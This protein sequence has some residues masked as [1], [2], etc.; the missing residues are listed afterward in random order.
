[1]W[2]TIH[3]ISQFHSFSIALNSAEKINH[4]LQNG[5]Q[6]ATLNYTAPNNN[7]LSNDLQ[8]GSNYL[9]F[10]F[11][12]LIVMTRLYLNIK[13]NFLIIFSNYGTPLHQK[14]VG[15][16]FSSSMVGYQF[17]ANWILGWTLIIESDSGVVQPKI[18]FALNWYPTMWKMNL[19]STAGLITLYTFRS[20]IERRIEQRIG[21]SSEFSRTGMSSIT[22]VVTA[23]RTLALRV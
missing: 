10:K 12:D 4:I 3:T 15:W 20:F 16:I 8:V 21:C 19:S 5:E 6:N 13:S 23:V 2:I 11:P 7:H 22:P 17:K 1:M 14:I 18:Q 9:L